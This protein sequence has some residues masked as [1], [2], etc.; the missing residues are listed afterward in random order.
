M[1]PT[2]ATPQPAT[3]SRR[4]A[5]KAF[6]TASLLPLLS[7]KGAL[8]FQ[9]LQQTQ[10][11]PQLLVL[12][13]TQYA[14]VEAFAEAIIPT[15]TR[16]PGAKAARVADYIDLLLSE[17]DSRTKGLWTEGLQALDHTALQRYNTTFVRLASTQVEELLTDISRNERQ[18]QT[19]VEQFFAMTKDATI[20]GYYT[21]EIGIHQELKYKGNQFLAEFAGCATE[22]GKECPH[23]GQKP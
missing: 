13:P 21:S 14:T 4:D 2:S 12:T 17:A 9:A 3:V 23:C 7:P 22:D 6:G 5:L 15:D 1:S 19:S 11:P 8:A 20:R 16:S 10:A 18:P